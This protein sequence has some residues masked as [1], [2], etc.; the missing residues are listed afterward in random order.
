VVIPAPTKTVYLCEL[1]GNFFS[2]SEN[3]MRINKQ[4]KIKLPIKESGYRAL[5]GWRFRIN[6]GK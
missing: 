1:I 2:N 4:M 3:G 5:S 6:I